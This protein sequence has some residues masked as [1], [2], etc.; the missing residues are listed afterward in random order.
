MTFDDVEIDLA[1][2]ELR[3]AGARVPVEPKVFDLIAYLA[4]NANR[5]ISKDE[6]IEHVWSGRIVSDAA[7]SSAIKSA[8]AALKSPSSPAP[9]S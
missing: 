1:R 8:R 6:M 9:A 3:R 4:G 5:L 7:L 2:Y